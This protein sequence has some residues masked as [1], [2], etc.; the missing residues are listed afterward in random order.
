MRWA[1]RRRAARSSRAAGSSSA[2]VPS[3]WIC[4]ASGPRLRNGR[5]RVRALSHELADLVERP[6]AVALEEHERPLEELVLDEQ[7]EAV[8]DEQIRRREHGRVAT[9]GVESRCSASATTRGARRRT[10]LGVIGLSGRLKNGTSAGCGRKTKSQSG[11]VACPLQHVGGHGGNAPN[12]S[13]SSAMLWWADQAMR[14][15]GLGAVGAMRPATRARRA[16]AGRLSGAR[17]P[18]TARRARAVPA[19]LLEHEVVGAEHDP[20]GPVV[21]AVDRGVRASR[22]ATFWT[23]FIVSYGT[24]TGADEPSCSVA[25]AAGMSSSHCDCRKTRS[26]SSA[27]M[28]V[29]ARPRIIVDGDATVARR[30]P[31]SRTAVHLVLEAERRVAVEAARDRHDDR[32]EVVGR[33]PWLEHD[34]GAAVPRLD[35]VDEEHDPHGLDGAVTGRS[36]RRRLEPAAP[37]PSDDCTCSAQGPGGE[38]FAIESAMP[39]KCHRP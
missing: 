5:D 13:S 38:P 35:Q 30:L 14:A 12:S 20:R 29:G 27:W 6:V 21:R 2:S 4:S 15:V 7:A 8:G 1:G 39:W 31:R 33:A 16:G 3:R 37:P 24:S 25:N 34:V 22:S 28:S 32:L 23:M 36:A 10:R 9:A 19:S 26:G 11:R 18:G 17:R